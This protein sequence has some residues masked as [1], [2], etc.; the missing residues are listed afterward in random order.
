MATMKLIQEGARK[1]LTSRNVRM[2][3]KCAR[4][5]RFRP[6]RFITSEFN[7]CRENSV[8]V[9]RVSAC[10][11]RTECKIRSSCQAV[12]IYCQHDKTF[13]VRSKTFIKCN[14]Q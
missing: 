11:I 6:L 1:K 14:I 12:S 2:L 3:L 5:H 7:T 8:S 13:Q 9:S 4:K 10:Y